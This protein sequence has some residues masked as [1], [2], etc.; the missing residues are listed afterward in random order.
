MSDA[1]G[2]PVEIKSVRFPA[3][4]VVRFSQMRVI[5]PETK[6]VFLQI[7]QWELIEC[8]GEMPRF[9]DSAW[10]SQ[11]NGEGD[12][13][14]PR[15]ET[16]TECLDNI[17]ARTPCKRGLLASFG[18][19]WSNVFG[20]QPRY[21]HCEI[22]KISCDDTAVPQVKD[23]LLA[24]AAKQPGAKTNRSSTGVNLKPTVLF[25]GSL[26]VFRTNGKPGNPTLP[27]WEV[28]DVSPRQ[29]QMPKPD[30]V[31][32]TDACL[33]FR[34][35]EEQT[36]LLAIFQQADQP[37]DAQPFGLAVS[38]RRHPAAVTRVQFT[39]G[40]NEVPNRILT[41]LDPFFAAF[42]Q[43][44]RFSGNIIAEKSVDSQK[45]RTRSLELNQAAFDKVALD[46]LSSKS[47]TFRLDGTADKLMLD[48]VRFSGESDDADALRLEHARGR[49]YNA[50]GLASWSGLRRL[51]QGTK[52]QLSPRDAS[53]PDTDIY[54]R[55][56]T[57]A[58]QID[59]QG[60]QLYPAFD[61]SQQRLPLLVIDNHCNI[62]LPHP[63]YVIRYVDLLASLAQPNT[64]QIP[65]MPETKYLISTLPITV[66][67]NVTATNAPF[68]QVQQQARLVEAVTETPE[69]LSSSINPMNL[70]PQQPQPMMP[71][72]SL[73]QAAP[74]EQYQQQTPR[75]A[76]LAMGHGAD[77]TRQPDFPATTQWPPQDESYAPLQ[78][79]SESQ[80]GLQRSSESQFGLQQNSFPQATPTSQPTLQ[81]LRQPTQSLFTQL[82]SPQSNGVPY[83]SQPQPLLAAHPSPNKV[84]IPE[85]AGGNS[86]RV[87][88]GR[89]LVAPDP[90]NN[91]LPALFDPYQQTQVASAGQPPR[92]DNS[93]ATYSSSS[94]SS[95]S[96][97]LSSSPFGL[98][99]T[100]PPYN[101]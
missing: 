47:L 89:S 79:P 63:G 14:S 61:E 94:V 85:I 26:E 44:S 67:R 76:Q 49:M 22:P 73:T 10:V 68:P 12:I 60:I 100:N 31:T 30:C 45:N 17:R 20:K 25:V 32:I 90:S 33:E 43:E 15:R 65:L 96:E 8:F 4:G 91:E 7:P 16:S 13:P 23:A 28:A 48:S 92:Y 40:D 59:A 27:P 77:G 46:A 21:W 42:G 5:D 72:P 18:F 83:G 99:G 71:V 53:P 38:C 19:A 57:F 6:G 66:E 87:K 93:S 97:P 37:S 29:S 55:K 9:M 11:A 82:Q 39:S 70:P 24:L 75:Q 86:N 58:F 88:T 95:S 84:V 74:T 80:F 51:V 36:T 101:R 2:K 1:L 69:S 62:F 41:G 50:K 35:T 3:P 78:R 54:F 81:P 64:Q 56:G 52:L 34:P 98:L